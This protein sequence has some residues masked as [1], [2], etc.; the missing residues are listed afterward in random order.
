VHAVRVLHLKIGGVRLGDVVHAD[1]AVHVVDVHEQWHSLA[2]RFSI[3]DGSAN[4]VRPGWHIGRVP[5]VGGGSGIGMPSWAAMATAR[6]RLGTP[7]LRSTAETWWPT[8]F[9]DSRNWPASSALDSPR[10]S[11]CST[12]SS[13]AVSPAGLSRVAGRGPRGTVTP[14]S[15]R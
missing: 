6:A 2:F 11:H 4:R 12:S 9:S 8:V 5:Y 15:R 1:L 13:R 14:R 3:W 10:P 7:S